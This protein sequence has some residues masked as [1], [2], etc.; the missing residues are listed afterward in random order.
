VGL[1]LTVQAVYRFDEEIIV[2]RLHENRGECDY[3]PRYTVF[4]VTTP[5]MRKIHIKITDHDS[6]IIKELPK[7][8]TEKMSALAI[9]S[10]DECNSNGA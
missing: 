9:A 7:T 2:T 10:V 3:L 1:D 8:M 4:T 6:I 5:I